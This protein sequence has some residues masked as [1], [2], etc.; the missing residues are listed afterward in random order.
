[1][2]PG[3]KAVGGATWYGRDCM[4]G[5]CGAAWLVLHAGCCFYIV[6][7]GEPAW[8]VWVG[9]PSLCKAQN[10]VEDQEWSSIVLYVCSDKTAGCLV[11]IYHRPIK[12]MN[13]C[14]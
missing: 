11:F 9:L 4:I 2:G 8:V 13:L 5:M 6:N 7:V 3:N 1:M 12:H 10:L 14:L